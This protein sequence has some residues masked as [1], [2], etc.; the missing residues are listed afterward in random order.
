MGQKLDLDL[1]RMGY[2]SYSNKNYDTADAVLI[3][4][5][6]FMGMFISWYARGKKNEKV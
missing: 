6:F 3:S 2:D 5:A 4:L 1:L